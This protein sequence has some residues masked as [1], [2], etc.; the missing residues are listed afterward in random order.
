MNEDF[1]SVSS[2]QNIETHRYTQAPV[3]TGVVIQ[4]QIGKKTDAKGK[5]ES[6]GSEAAQR[7]SQGAKIQGQ[8]DCV[9]IVG[10]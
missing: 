1:K 2:Q 10:T 5:I 9:H 8:A 6:A 4:Y 7:Q 3:K